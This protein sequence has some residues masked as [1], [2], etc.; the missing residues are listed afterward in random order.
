M[1]I[2]SERRGQLGNRLFL[3]AYGMALAEASSQRLFDLS[4]HEYATYF[5][6]TRRRGPAWFHAGVRKLA[7]AMIRGIRLLPFMR[8]CFVSVGWHTPHSH[9]P[10]DPT[11]LADVQSRSLNF[12]EGYPELR[13]VTFP[14]TG[15]IRAKFIP[16]A[17]I[18]ETVRA[19]VAAARE[20]ADVLIGVHIRHGD[21]AYF[22]GGIYFYPTRFYQEVM[23]RM[24]GFFPGRRVAF[25]VCANAPQRFEGVLPFKVTN[26][27]GSIMG[28]LYSL[29]ECDYILGAPSSFSHWAAFYGRKPI[30]HLFKQR[31]P[32][33]LDEFTIHDGSFE[34]FDS[35]HSRD[36]L[37]ELQRKND[38]LARSG[39]L[40]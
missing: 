33:S 30:L 31:L 10:M 3:H 28:D 23:E 5:P 35:K 26:G 21:Y 25:L 27:P 39:H 37:V 14:S 4:L 17:E 22:C 18:R 29:A 16:N 19:R 40:E 24:A 11:F 7:R 9:S 20:G 1:I 6:A 13:R 36:E 8:S 2:L 15:T 32:D 12:I 34:S 38:A